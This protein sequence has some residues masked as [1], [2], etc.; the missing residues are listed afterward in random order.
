MALLR[1]AVTL[2]GL[3]LT[4]SLSSFAQS[5]GSS[6]EAPGKPSVH[7]QVRAELESLYKIC[8]HLN[9]NHLIALIATTA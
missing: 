9:N 7:P 2:V 3:V 5:S 6:S 1:T 4:T 8:Y